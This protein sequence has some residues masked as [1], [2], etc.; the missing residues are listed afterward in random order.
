VFQG[1]EPGMTSLVHLCFGHFSCAFLRSS[2]EVEHLACV[3]TFVCF[4]HS[5]QILLSAVTGHVCIWVTITVIIYRLSLVH[6]A[7]HSF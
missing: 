6:L 3:R 1:R 7:A 4:D 5:T 2:A